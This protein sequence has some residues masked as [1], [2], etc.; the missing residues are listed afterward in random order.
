MQVFFL[1]VLSNAVKLPRVMKNVALKEF[2]L[3]PT[4]QI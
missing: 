3:A 4:K 1:T 2:H